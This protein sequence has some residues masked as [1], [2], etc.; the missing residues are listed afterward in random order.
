[1]L[2]YTVVAVELSVCFFFFFSSRRRHTRWPRDWSSDVCS[3]DLCGIKILE[4]KD[5][6]ETWVTDVC[7]YFVV[8]NYPELGK[9][10]KDGTPISSRF[11]AIP[12][13]SAQVT[14]ERNKIVHQQG[15]YVIYRSIGQTIKREIIKTKSE[16]KNL[17]DLWVAIR[18]CF[19]LNDEASVQQIRDDI[20][21]WDLEKAGNWNDW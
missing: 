4:L 10:L 13:E 5:D 15:R 6:Y 9:A 7:E 21:G 20:A 1:M 18:D 8:S 2:Q 3:S 19:Y 12:G 14:A 11:D 16:T 17:A